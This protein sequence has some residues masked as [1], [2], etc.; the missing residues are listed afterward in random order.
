MEQPERT[1]IARQTE[2]IQQATARDARRRALVAGCVGNLV[3]WYDFAL[4]GAF[5]TVLAAAFFP[6]ADPV[7]GLLADRR[8]GYGGW[9]WATVA[10]GLAAGI[11]TAA[12][13]A[14]LR[15]GRVSGP[16]TAGRCGPGGAGAT[17]RP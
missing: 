3:D 17:P 7:S 2:Q 8:G 5:A 16:V 11:A 10:L 12:R 1:T 9:Q 13:L 4:Y 15:P 6:E 14:W